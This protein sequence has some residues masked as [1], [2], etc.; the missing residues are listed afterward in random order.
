MPTHVWGLP[1][2]GSRLGGREGRAGIRPRKAAR[3]SAGPSAG[4]VLA[5]R[6]AG[7]RARVSGGMRVGGA[8]RTGMSAQSPL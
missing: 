5:E 3:R 2:L 7:G 6:P 4:A 1:L 8:D